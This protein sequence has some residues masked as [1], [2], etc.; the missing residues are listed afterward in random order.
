M[1]QLLAAF[2]F[3]SAVALTGNI[4]LAADAPPKDSA[5]AKKPLEKPA[6]VSADA[7]AK[8]SEADKL[9]AIEAAKA[10]TAKAPAPKKE[11]KGGC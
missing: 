8:M 2:V 11:K 6:D 10:K 7:W 3:G 1:K 9:K 5:A 4:A